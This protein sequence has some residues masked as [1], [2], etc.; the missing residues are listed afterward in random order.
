MKKFLCMI[1]CVVSVMFCSSFVSAETSPSS[2]ITKTNKVSIS[3]KGVT[4]VLSDENRYSK[5]TLSAGTKITV[6]NTSS[7][8]K[9]YI[10]WDKP[11]GEWTLSTSKSQDVTYGQKGFMHE[12]IELPIATNDF[13]ITIKSPSVIICDIYTFGDGDVPDWVQNWNIPYDDADM[14]LLPTHGDDELIFF[15]GTIPYYAG[16][17]GYRVQVAYM[18]NHWGEPYRPHEILNAMWASGLKAYP[19]MGPFADI[20]STSIEH[21]KKVYDYQKIVEFN[22]ELIRRFKPEVIIGHDLKGE[23]GH[24][25]HMINSLA[26]TE[27]LDHS[28]DSSFAP[29]SAQKYGVWDVQKTYL[30]LYAEN[31]L[32]M[33]WDI[34]LSKFGGKTSFEVA[35][36]AFDN[37]YTSQ[38]KYYSVKKVKGVYDNTDFGLYRTTVGND[39]LK[40][41]FFENIPKTSLTPEESSIPESTSSLESTDDSS[42]VTLDNSPDKNKTSNKALVL[43]AFISV[44]AA[45]VTI[46]IISIIKRINKNK[47][48]KIKS[49]RKKVI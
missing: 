38:K 19:I 39:I 17:L 37:Y 22:T 31:K 46:V 1:V 27:A 49:R 33:N 40:K 36:D 4:N 32:Y 7:I 44:S 3:D 13:T 16:E 2:E 20:Y 30:H 21:A 18:T 35:R 42:D 6:T 45:L 48:N 41:D 28:A 5:L 25:G 26:L 14:L 34:P 23:Y 43:V 9:I 29:E 8:S 10:V 11:P 15:G 24:G 47:R 12:Y